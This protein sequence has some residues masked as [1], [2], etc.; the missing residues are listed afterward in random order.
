MFS[1][2]RDKTGF[3]VTIIL[4]V[5]ATGTVISTLVLL[6]V[7]IAQG[8]WKEHLLSVKWILGSAW[9]ACIITV[10]IRLR[11]YKWQYDRAVQKQQAE[12]Q[13]ETGEPSSP[14]S[15]RRES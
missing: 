10:L 13:S 7:G 11:I 9:V 12:Q 2:R 15:G 1:F 3:F 4:I 6:I 14:L 5:I 8:N